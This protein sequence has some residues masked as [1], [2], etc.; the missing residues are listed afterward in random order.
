MAE[1]RRQQSQMLVDVNVAHI[2]RIVPDH[3]YHQKLSQNVRHHLHDVHILDRKH[4][5]FGRLAYHR[6]RYIIV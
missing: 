2:V 5:L 6:H 4:F 3:A 1:R